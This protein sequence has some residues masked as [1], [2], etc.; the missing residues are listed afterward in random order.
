MR[1][2][3]LI[4]EMA[5]LH[6]IS[7]QTLRYYDKIGLFKPQHI[8][9]EN[10]YRYYD[11]EQFATLD[12]ILFF[13]KLGVPLEEIK[14]YFH[15]RDLNSMIRLLKHQEKMIIREVETLN[16]HLNSIRSRVE[17]IENYQNNDSAYK[18]SIRELKPRK[19]AY[20]NLEH[21]IDTIDFEYGLKELYKMLKD[22]LSLFNGVIACITSK[23]DI[24]KGNYNH[25][26]TVGL[27]F[28]E[29]I[30]NGEHLNILPKSKYATIAY[31]G[32]NDECGKYYEEL[33][34]Y[35]KDNKLEVIGDGIL[36]TIIDS[37]FSDY[38][39]EYIKEIQIPIKNSWHYNYY[40]L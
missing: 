37:A 32:D 3:V 40:N 39:E 13:K 28:E 4:G 36:I 14:D 21:H 38:K 11:I 8:D 10:K 12:S 29:D 17:L 15:D 34:K 20:F 24:E 27:I 9:Y 31:N 7:A 16:K 1:N 33:M 5:K 6:N 25:C 26:K 22:D 2:K 30:I 18:C 23:E 35:I 19:I